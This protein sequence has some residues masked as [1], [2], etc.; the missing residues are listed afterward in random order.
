[1]TDLDS[2]MK[3]NGS[4]AVGTSSIVSSSAQMSAFIDVSAKCHDFSDRGYFYCRG[5]CLRTVTF[6]VSPAETEYLSLRIIKLDSDDSFDFPGYFSPEPHDVVGW[7]KEHR[8]FA[9]AL[10]VGSYRAV[11]IHTQTLEESWPVFVETTFE[12]AQCSPLLNVFGDIQLSVPPPSN[13]QHCS[14][15]IRNGDM[16]DSNTSYPHWLHHNSGQIELLPGAGLSDSNAIADTDYDSSDAYIGQFLDTRCIQEGNQYN[17]RVWVKLTSPDGSRTISCEGEDSCPAIHLRVRSP[18][19]PAGQSF[20]EYTAA[21]S[22]SFVP[23]FDDGS[24]LNDSW[25]LLQCTVTIDARIA[26]AASVALVVARG[27][28]GVKMHL[29]NVSM[30]LLSKDCSELVYNGDFS[31]GDSTFWAMDPFNSETSQL[32]FVSSPGNAALRLTSRSSASDSI[33]QNI[34]TGCMTASERYLA[35]AKVRLLEPA[36]NSLL[37]CDHNERQGSKACPRMQLKS[38]VDVGLPTQDAKSH[39][40]GGIADMNFGVTSDGW[41]TLSGIFSASTYDELSE[42]SVLSIAD[43]FVSG[44]DVM[45]DD[46]SIQHLPKSCSELFMNG[47][48]SNGDT[49]QFWRTALVREP[50]TIEIVSIGSSSAFKVANRELVGDGLQQTVD[51]R[52]LENGDSWKVSAR[53]KLVNIDGSN[54]SCDPLATKTSTRCPPIRIIG[55]KEGEKIVDELFYLSNID[56]WNSSTNMRDYEVNFTVSP[57][58]A[59]CD[60]VWIGIRSYNREWDLI[61]DDLSMTPQ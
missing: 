22:S 26:E 14:Q 49:V 33:I 19:D 61:V 21:L 20:S 5:T 46:I 51:A 59:D 55:S 45:I 50:T 43:G 35:F 47:S 4:T 48:P 1:L 6:A 60:E 23:P 12:T 13:A 44:T 37:E 56:A 53:M 54:A 30:T 17:V 2:S 3:P 24:L 42:K 8:Y 32:V 10:P 39:S 11:F 34:Q 27:S 18:E 16:E 28:Q 57:D 58:L 40:N 29:D 52:C 9:A 36:S 15:L 38:F 41:Y 25:S 31:S 7:I